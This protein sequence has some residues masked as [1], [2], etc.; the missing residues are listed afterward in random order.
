MM[1]LGS[2]FDGSGGFPLAGAMHGIKPVWASEIEP[3][4]IRVTKARFPNMEHLGS[5]LDVNGAEIEPVDII[6]FGSP[7]QDLSVAGKQKGIHEGERSSLFFEAVRIAKEMRVHDR[8]IGRTGVDVRPRFLVWENVPGAFSSHQG[9][10][11]R[12]VL[13]ALGGI[14]Q[15]GV[16]IPRP[17]KGKWE[18]AGCVV[19]DG[20]SIAWR[21]YDAQYWGVPQRRKRIY[22]VAD[23]ASERAGEILFERES[24]CGNPAEGG[25]AREGIAHDAPGGAGGSCT[26]F[27]LQQDPINGNVSPCIGGQHQATVGV[28]A[29]FKGGQGPKAGSIGYQEG[30]APTL[31]SANSGT[32]TV[33]D[34]VYQRA[35][36]ITGTSSNSMK[37]PTPDSCFRER[38]IGRT[39][40]T[41]V[42]SPECNQGGMVVVA[43]TDRHGVVHSLDCR[44][45][46]GE[47]EISGTL[48][49]KSNG[50]QSLNYQNPV[51]YDTTQIT[52]PLNYSN[53]KPGDPCHPLAAQQHPPL[54][55]G[56][57]QLHQMSMAEQSNTLDCMHDQQAGLIQGEHP[58]KYIVRRL[59]PLECCRLQGFPDW[60]EDGVKG[61]DS[62]R[63][64][65][66]GNGIALPCA[67]D[68]LGRITKAI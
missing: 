8:A 34:V 63:Y 14:A 54:C 44:N 48:Q 19:G 32:N 21:L 26:A 67:A 3:Y 49:A 46:R 27:H 4:P 42:G 10:D 53:P 55:V 24:L 11:F 51:I 56:N 6:T 17:T 68:V 45:M 7:C 35:F 20:W 65:M 61:S 16:S 12:A 13:E 1:T 40:D 36:D 50:G 52:S 2:L 64:K 66:W 23:L 15:D 25:E 29:S 37:S 43:E 39:L 38:T 30:Q 33:P 5:V 60:W 47:F 58:R 62:A 18:H 59:T 9:E 41:F 31:A 22:L 57:G 28:V